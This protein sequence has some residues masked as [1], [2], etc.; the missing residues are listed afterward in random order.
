M[1]NSRNRRL[2]GNTTGSINTAPRHTNG[3]IAGDFISMIPRRNGN[4]DGVHITRNTSSTH[5]AIVDRINT[6]AAT[7]NSN[8]PDKT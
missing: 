1:I 6:V 7:Q 2:S 5:F 8:R 3:N 4:I